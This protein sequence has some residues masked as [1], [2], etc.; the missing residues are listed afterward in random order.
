MVRQKVARYTAL[1]LRIR[2][3]PQQKT[4]LEKE[5]DRRG[6]N[7]SDLVREFADELARKREAADA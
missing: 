6:C 5:A 2:V 1:P 7:V 3:T 4:A